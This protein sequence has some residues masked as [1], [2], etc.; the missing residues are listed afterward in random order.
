MMTVTISSMVVAEIAP[1]HSVIL[2]S[3]LG[4]CELQFPLKIRNTQ[5][6]GDKRSAILTGFQVT[7]QGNAGGEQPVGIAR[8]EVPFRVIPSRAGSTRD[9]NFSAVIQ[10]SQVLAIENLRDGGDLTFK[11]TLCGEGWE[12]DSE[13][14]DYCSGSMRVGRSHWI[15]QLKNSRM[16]EVLLIEVPMPVV[17]LPKTMQ[18]VRDDLLKAQR[19]FLLADYVECVATCRHV[20]DEI[21]NKAH[22][23]N[24]SGPL[25]SRLAKDRDDPENDREKMKKSEREAAVMASVRHYAHPAHHAESDGGEHYSRPEAKLILSLTAAISARALEQ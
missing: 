9:V 2:R 11:L 16:L 10:P 14:H 8:P 24:W 15:D 1:A 6:E 7:V 18:K 21:G 4:A 20:L 19:F 12:E 17:D 22:G 5:K 13:R 23:K 25:L 3:L